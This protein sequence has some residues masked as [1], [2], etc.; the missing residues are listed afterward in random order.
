MCLPVGI[1]SSRARYIFVDRYYAAIGHMCERVLAGNV[2]SGRDKHAR[3]GKENH[4]CVAVE[5]LLKY[6]RRVGGINLN[7]VV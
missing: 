4:R 6:A 3:K 2:V 7:M 5:I 1:H